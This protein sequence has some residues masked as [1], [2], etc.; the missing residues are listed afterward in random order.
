VT[1]S[2]GSSA[3]LAWGDDPDALTVVAPGFE[4][5]DHFYHEAG[6]YTVRLLVEGLEAASATVTI[7]VSDCHAILLETEDRT[8]TI[9]VWGRFGVDY[10]VIWGDGTSHPF[11]GSYAPEQMSH[12]YALPGTYTIRMGGTWAPAQPKIEVTIE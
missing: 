3:H 9:R 2:L 7:E 10:R 8:V 5:Y 11:I 6:E 1:G 4:L 12:T